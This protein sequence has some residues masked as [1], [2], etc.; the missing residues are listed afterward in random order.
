[1]RSAKRTGSGRVDRH[2]QAKRMTA[3]QE[4][5]TLSDVRREAR[6]GDRRIACRPRKSTQL[7]V[8]EVLPVLDRPGRRW[9]NVAG[10]NEMRACGE[11]GKKNGPKP[12]S[13]QAPG[14]DIVDHNDGD[15]LGAPKRLCKFSNRSGL[16]VKELAKRRQN[17]R[18]GGLHCACRN[19][20]S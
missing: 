12:G 17:C 14:I 7:D 2:L 6:L 8:E 13:C 1:A 9:R 20:Q 16:L 10:E 19:M 11:R 4:P 18:R 15:V 5:D 3:T